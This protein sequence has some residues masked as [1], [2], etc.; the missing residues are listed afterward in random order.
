VELKEVIGW[1]RSIRFYWPYRPV[2]RAKV[3]KMLEAA[4]RASCV[5]NVNNTRAV[6]VWRD[7]AS[8]QLLKALTPPLGYQQMQT[9][10]CFII[11][12]SDAAAYAPEAWIGNIKGLADMR[13][14]GSDI[15]ATK[16]QIDK[17]L[18]PLF[19]AMWPQAAVAPLA[20]M[21]LG[22]AVAQATLVAYDEGL[23]TC[24]MSGP[25][26]LD[27]VT[28]L[29][30][31]PETATIVCV[32]SVGYPA[33]SRL[34]GGQTVKAP[35]ESLFSEMEYGRPMKLSSRTEEELK[36]AKLIQEQAPLPWREE[37]LKTVV[38]AL[39]IEEDRQIGISPTEES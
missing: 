26:M 31:L 1:R 32:M 38:R 13:R 3:E 5:G 14:M 19:T 6:V 27:R 39:G 12:Y 10:P 35:F 25:M 18:R 28:K 22:Q 37:E 4:R 30:K 2:E 16:R 8:P 9:A 21:D 15:E 34:A 17:S 7:Q 36:Q 24:L 29:L 23:G 11:W 33:E 20:F